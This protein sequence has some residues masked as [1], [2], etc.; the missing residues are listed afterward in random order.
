MNCNRIS[1]A[2]AMAALLLLGACG[3]RSEP[4]SPQS[5]TSSLSSSQT[6]SD[7]VNQAPAEISLTVKGESHVI[8]AGTEPICF[9]VRSL[10]ELP[11]P[12]HI[13]DASCTISIDGENVYSG[14]IAGVADFV[15]PRNGLYDYCIQPDGNSLEEYRFQ[16]DCTLPPQVAPLDTHVGVGEVLVLQARYTDGLALHVETNLNFT[17]QFFPDGDVQ[18]ALIPARLSLN[19]GSYNL[20]VQAG[21]LTFR[22][23]IQ[24]DERE[25]EVQYLEIDESTV[26]DTTGNDSARKQFPAWM[27]F[28]AG[29]CRSS[30]PLWDP[31]FM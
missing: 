10:E 13:Q 31:N 14:D 5:V 9:P 2:A 17:P 20:T 6:S 15:P 4:A 1:V 23:E 7:S 26:S 18:T 12:E 30:G 16:A 19:P 8:Q 24:V 22:F 29:N 11:L 21:E 3:S 28:H 27:V 25:F